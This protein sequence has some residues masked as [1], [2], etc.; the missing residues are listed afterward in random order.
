MKQYMHRS[1][2]MS[3]KDLRGDGRRALDNNT[4]KSQV[5]LAFDPHS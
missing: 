3:L 5:N 4:Y 2:M 1:E